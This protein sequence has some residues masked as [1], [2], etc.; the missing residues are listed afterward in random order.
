MTLIQLIKARQ[1]VAKYAGE[2]ISTALSYKLVKFIKATDNDESFYN[3]KLK[4]IL[5]T[6]VEKDDEGNYVQHG[7]GFK[8]KPDQIQECN[9]ENLELEN[10]EV[11]LPDIHFTVSE[12]EDLKL[13]MRE[14]LSLD[15]LITEE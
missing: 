15:E 3:D 14:I 6:Y 8:I 4:S 9:K 1:I 13:S 5:E 11:T 10:T 12:L 7:N 2:K